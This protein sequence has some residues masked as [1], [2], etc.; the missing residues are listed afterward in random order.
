MEKPSPWVICHDAQRGGAQRLDQD[1]IPTHWIC[2]TLSKRR[3][4]CL[5]I[6]RIVL[7]SINNHE[8]VS[9]QMAMK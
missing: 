2:L 3:I 9:V 8:L 1:G 4:K 7:C 5:V 6:G